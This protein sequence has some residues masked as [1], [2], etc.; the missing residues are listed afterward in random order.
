MAS[1][2]VMSTI[3]ALLYDAGH[4][5]LRPRMEAPDIWEFLGDQL[6]LKLVRDKALP[7][8]GHHF[9]S[10]FGEDGM[11]AYDSDEAA[12]SFWASYYIQAM[13]ETGVD[14]PV[15]T[16][17]SA[18]DALYDWYQ[19]PDQWETYP[20]TFETLE[21]AAALDLKQGIIS[22]WGTDLIRI[23]HAHEV[24]RHLDF[25][26][27]SAAVGIAK[28]H[29]DIFR[30]A[31]VR[32]QLQ[33]HEVMYVGDSYISD[34]LGARTVGIEAVLIDREG[35]APEVDCPVVASLLELFDLIH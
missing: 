18:A 14:L 20:E 25:V 6:G 21:R 17:H 29:A 35:R 4:T 15:E 19:E 33:P 13:R 30:H 22:D 28:P 34:V 7:D 23:L 5:L 26:V 16:L 9:Y 3:R 8:V 32:A 10:R 11:G 27:A 31:L 24:T 2:P 1:Q 12:R